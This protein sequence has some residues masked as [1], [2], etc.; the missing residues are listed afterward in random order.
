MMSQRGGDEE[1]DSARTPV[2]GTGTWAGLL[3]KLQAQPHVIALMD[4]LNSMLKQVDDTISPE[5]MLAGHAS[6]C[7]AKPCIGESIIIEPG[8]CITLLPIPLSASV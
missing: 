8:C 3:A 2:W 7:E 1:E 6:Y 5:Q 4:E